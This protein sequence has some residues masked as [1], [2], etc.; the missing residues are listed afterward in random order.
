M[1]FRPG[2]ITAV[3][4]GTELNAIHL[5]SRSSGVRF[6]YDQ[7][8]DVSHRH[9]DFSQYSCS[10][11]AASTSDLSWFLAHIYD[12]RRSLIPFFAAA[13]RLKTRVVSRAQSSVVATGHASATR[14]GTANV[15]GRGLVLGS[16][17]SLSPPFRTF[18]G[19]LPVFGPRPSGH[20]IPI[21]EL[22]YFNNLVYLDFIC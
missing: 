17:P 4:Y 18:A 6:E 22:K 5:D 10:P 14:S 3:P 11:Q 12:R 13:A 16:E 7:S 1:P 8:A 20:C 21:K 19:L 15:I 2:A 9:Y